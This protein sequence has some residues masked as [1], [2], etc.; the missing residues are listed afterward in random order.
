MPRQRKEET[1]LEAWKETRPGTTPVGGLTRKSVHSFR[2]FLKQQ[3]HR[4][5]LHATVSPGY[6]GLQ[7]PC[8]QCSKPPSS[9]PS[10]AGVEI[11]AAGAP[12]VDVSQQRESSADDLKRVVQMV[13]C[14]ESTDGSLA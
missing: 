14:S 3:G 12:G 2:N 13:V 5:G 10:L 11:P 8:P 7:Q 9:I 4:A 1:K 6:W